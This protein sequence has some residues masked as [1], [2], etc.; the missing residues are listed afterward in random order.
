MANARSFAELLRSCRQEHVLSQRELARRVGAP[1]S[2]ISAYES[3]S[4]QPT[5]AAAN[6]ILGSLDLQVVLGVEPRDADLD[7]L[8]D[9]LRGT[10]VRQRLMRIRSN[11]LGLMDFLAPAD[12]LLDGA[13][14]AL[15]YGVPTVARVTDLCIRSS[16]IDVVAGELAR[17][18]PHRW[19][20]E[21][22]EYSLLAAPD[23]RTPGPMRWNTHLGELRIWFCDELPTSVKINIPSRDG[24]GDGHDISLVTIDQIGALDPEL[25]RLVDRAIARS[26]SGRE[27]GKGHGAGGCNVE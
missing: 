13:A 24:E 26:R 6:A 1:A 19:S 2:R 11:V 22:Q 4:R 10:T 14:A 16:L 8:I 15:L 23:P 9:A 20:Q 27:L 17:F 25:G 12:P 3:G 18:R 7:R 5:V 21:L